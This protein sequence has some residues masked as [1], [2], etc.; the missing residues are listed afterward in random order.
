[1]GEERSGGAVCTHSAT[2]VTEEEVCVVPLS[3]EYRKVE[4]QPAW[5]WGPV[6]SRLPSPGAKRWGGPT[7]KLRHRPRSGL[8]KTRP[9][10]SV[11]SRV[12]E[13]RNEVGSGRRS[14]GRSDSA[15]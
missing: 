8:L 15:K 1:V 3:D 10:K 7:S 11:L 6:G 5:S 9:I 14:G 2:S 12:R 13:G 4:T